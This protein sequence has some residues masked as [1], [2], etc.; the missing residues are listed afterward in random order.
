L[1]Q[2]ID[3]CLAQAAPGVETETLVIDDG[4]TDNT[5]EICAQFG[6]RIRVVRGANAGF[7]SSLT[8]AVVEARGD[9]V[10]L[11]DADDYFDREKLAASAH[12]LGEGFS[13]IIGSNYFVDENGGR[14]EERMQGGGNTSTLCVRR[15]A[16]ISLLPV[17]NELSFHAILAAG[18]GVYAPRALTYYR[19]HGGSMTNRTIPGKW[20]TYLAGVT[21][22][23]A[24]RMAGLSPATASWLQSVAQAK[25]I[26]GRFRAQA[27]YNELEA[28]LELHERGKAYRALLSMLWNEFKFRRC[29]SGLA[30]KMIVRTVLL[31]PTFPKTLSKPGSGHD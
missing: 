8:K 27:F 6:E 12:L 22:R 11:L 19:I 5:S 16:A 30:L 23:L 29:P 26:A 13:L 24:D 7:G 15:E 17:E 21:H 18:N 28:A 31:R 10:C 14:I 1:A 20:N 25:R 9:F 3:S 4:S 2:A